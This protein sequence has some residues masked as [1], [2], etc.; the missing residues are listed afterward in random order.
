LGFQEEEKG[1]REK[2][3]SFWPG[4]GM[5]GTYNHVRSWVAGNRGLRHQWMAGV[6]YLIRVEQEILCL[7]L[8]L[9]G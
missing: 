2:V 4:F 1:L 5:R 6:G 8:V 3:L 9:S 7:A